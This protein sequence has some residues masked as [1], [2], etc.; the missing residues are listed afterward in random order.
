[1]GG[2]LQYCVKRSKAYLSVAEAV[3]RVCGALWYAL[4]ASVHLFSGVGLLLGR[5]RFFYATV[6]DTRR[7]TPRAAFT[8]RTQIE[9]K[10]K[11]TEVHDVVQLTN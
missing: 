4:C 10:V 1:M 9:R 3:W 8:R 11:Q 6:W 7:F 5:F 2:P